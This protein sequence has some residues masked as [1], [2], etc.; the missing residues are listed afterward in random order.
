MKLHLRDM[1]WLILVA[2]LCTAWLIDRRYS[3]QVLASQRDQMIREFVR[4]QNAEAMGGV[5]IRYSHPL[6]LDPLDPNVVRP[7]SE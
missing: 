6:E 2:A 3:A 4:Q 1:F 7:I 5:Q